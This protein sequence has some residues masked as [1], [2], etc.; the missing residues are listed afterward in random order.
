MMHDSSYTADGCNFIARVV[1]DSGGIEDTFILYFICQSLPDQNSIFTSTC[2]TGCAFFLPSSK[3]DA[4]QRQTY[5]SHSC[6]SSI[7][8]FSSLRYLVCAMPDPDTIAT[9]AEAQQEL[10]EFANKRLFH[11]RLA[12]ADPKNLSWIGI[13]PSSLEKSG[14]S[15]LYSSGI[16]SHA[17]FQLLQVNSGS[18]RMPS[19]Q[20]CKS[21][22]RCSP[23]SCTSMGRSLVRSVSPV[24]S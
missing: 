3:G 24:S 18:T 7:S 21:E 2:V 22:C 23:L 4:D 11:Y 14:E 1:V 10:R 20:L 15:A 16:L 5:A 19:S 8:H 17:A 12:H 9:W 6:W 13:D